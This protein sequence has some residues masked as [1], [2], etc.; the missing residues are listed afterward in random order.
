[1]QITISQQASSNFQMRAFQALESN[2]F[3]EA[4]IVSL[5]ES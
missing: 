1:L 5:E 4:E 3:E 2:D